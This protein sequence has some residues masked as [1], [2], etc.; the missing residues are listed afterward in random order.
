MLVEQ[1]PSLDWCFA[2]FVSLKPEIQLIK[3]I[4]PRVNRKSSWSWWPQ[5]LRAAVVIEA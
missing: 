5:T 1:S 3:C 2:Q 4:S